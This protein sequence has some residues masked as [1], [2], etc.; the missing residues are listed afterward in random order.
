M[1]AVWI[2]KDS[3]GQ[4]LP[5]FA[6][7]SRL[8]VGRKVVPE[9]YDAFRLHVSSSCREVFERALQQVLEREAWQIVRVKN[10]G[11]SGHGSEAGFD[12]A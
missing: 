2:V 5:Q 6:S 11:S 9:R 1:S 3:S 7:T 10:S 8:E 12:A 4:L